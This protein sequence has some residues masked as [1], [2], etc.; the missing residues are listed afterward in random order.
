MTNLKYL[1]Y[2]RA[3]TLLGIKSPKYF[4]LKYTHDKIKNFNIKARLI[5]NMK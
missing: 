5:Y 1:D 2:Q 4:V 3:T